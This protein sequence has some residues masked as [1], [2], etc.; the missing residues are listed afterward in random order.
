MSNPVPTQST[1]DMPAKLRW[2]DRFMDRWG[3]P[4][5][6]LLALGVG[7]FLGMRWLANDIARP[8]VTKHCEFLDEKIKESIEI[9]GTQRTIADAVK[10]LAESRDKSLANSARQIEILDMLSAQQRT[11]HTQQ[12]MDHKT[13]GEKMNV[14]EQKMIPASSK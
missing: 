7:V 1:D 9:K 13:M 3:A 10:S 12:A 14:V 8:L 4:T 6:L 5:L 11:D 2:V